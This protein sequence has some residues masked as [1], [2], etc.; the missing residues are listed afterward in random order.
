M[1]KLLICITLMMLILLGC[2]EQEN[3]KNTRVELT[4]EQI[5]MPK[6]GDKIAIIKTSLGEVRLRLFEAIAPEAVDQFIMNVE[7]G[8][9]DGL[10]LFSPPNKSTSTFINANDLHVE[11]S[12]EIFE[13]FIPNRHEDYHHYTGAVGFTSFTTAD[14]KQVY[15]YKNFYIVGGDPLD[16]ETI[17][18]LEDLGFS[19]ESIETYKAIGGMP[20][21]DT[22]RDHPIFAQVYEGLEL[23]KDMVALES[24]PMSDG[25]GF[26]DPVYIESITIET[27]KKGDQ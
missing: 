16:Q 17:D 23:I 18:I 24:K 8:Y 25:F 15:F 22:D 3:T 5:Q 27:Y 2:D 19:E 12:V 11:K 9:Y 6:D 20:W 10:E 13:T 4:S 1:K 21:M 7:S 14:R 26:I